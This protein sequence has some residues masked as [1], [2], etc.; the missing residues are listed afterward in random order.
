MSLTMKKL[1]LLAVV[2]SASTLGRAAT[3]Q[4]FDHLRALTVARYP[5]G[6]PAVSVA[7]IFGSSVEGPK[8]IAVADLDGDGKQDF[9]AANKDGSVTVYFGAGDGSFGPRL[10]LRTWTNAPADAQGLFITS[11]FTNTCTSVWTNSWID[12]GTNNTN[13]AWIC[14]PA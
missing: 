13:W 14:L 8:D 10:N 4:L 12:H 1:L 11:Y 2:L 7:N 3:T 9:A 5:V 6:D